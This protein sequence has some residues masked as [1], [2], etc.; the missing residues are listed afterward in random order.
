MTEEE[1]NLISDLNNQ[2]IIDNPILIT[3][4]RFD[5]I[6]DELIKDDLRGLMWRLCATYPN[7]NYNKAVK[8]FI[9]KKDSWYIEEL[10]CFV[11]GELDQE[12]LVDKMIE[13]NDKDFIKDSLC[14]CGNCME[15][16]LE[17][18]LLKKLYLF[19]EKY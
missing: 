17:P 15:F 7:Y 13:T 6:L 1:R 9:D 19:L 12:Y 4:D 18:Y 8:Y 5:F 16:C 11:N 3:Q 2:G 10:V 14:L